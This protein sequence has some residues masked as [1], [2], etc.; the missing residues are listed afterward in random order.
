MILT[1]KYSSSALG[2]A[3]ITIKTLTDINRLLS[4]CKRMFY[5]TLIFI[6]ISKKVEWSVTNVYFTIT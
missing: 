2:T 4:S 5:I 3:W 1:F 6:S